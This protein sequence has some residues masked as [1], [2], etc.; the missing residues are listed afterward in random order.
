MDTSKE[1]EKE[2]TTNLHESYLHRVDIIPKKAQLL[3]SNNVK[4][5][6][7]GAIYFRRVLAADKS[8]PLD[9]IFENGRIVPA[10]VQFLTRFEESKLQLEAAWSIT[11]I[12]CGDI[13]FIYKLLEFGTIDY[14]FQIVTYGSMNLIV[15]EDNNS[16]K[17]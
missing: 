15:P 17:R 12:A 8:P 7:D 13:E 11:N 14:L 5:Q 16:G 4:E 10:L 9:L 6:I 3:Y 1:T 2:K